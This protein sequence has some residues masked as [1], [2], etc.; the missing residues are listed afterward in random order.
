MENNY[1]IIPLF[2]TLIYN[3]TIP[4]NLSSIITWFDQQPLAEPEP[5]NS[6]FGAISKDTYILDNNE[7]TPLKNFIIG[8]AKNYA[9]NYLFY[10]KPEYKITQSWISHKNPGEE[11][12]KHN[13][14]NSLISGV[15]YYG[16][17]SN[18]TPSIIFSNPLQN[19]G[20]TP[21]ILVFPTQN[22]TD[23][24]FKPT[25]GTLLL[26]PSYLYHSVPKNTTNE[27]RKSLAFNIVPKDGFG[28]AQ[29]LNELKFN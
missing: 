17:S 4:Q 29:F 18:E 6:L 11:H 22:N 25:P 1:E 16:N 2:P 24:P 10:N 15:L 12:V 3:T 9:T 20:S 26:F 13:H 27:I 28:D 8:Q 5:N 21:S 7:C 19:T 14:T 23:I